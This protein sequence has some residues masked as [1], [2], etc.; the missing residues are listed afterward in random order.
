MHVMEKTQALRDLFTPPNHWIKQQTQC[1]IPHRRDTHLQVAK[2][3]KSE[4][5]VLGCRGGGTVGKGWKGM[6]WSWSGKRCARTNWSILCSP[7]L[8][9]KIRSPR[10]LEG[11]GVPLW[12]GGSWSFSQEVKAASDTPPDSSLPSPKEPSCQLIPGGL[13]LLL[14][15]GL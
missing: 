9:G 8:L 10:R 2:K 3:E 11:L 14:S 1:S 7:W 13:W 4:R 5:D 15:P 6:G 12:R